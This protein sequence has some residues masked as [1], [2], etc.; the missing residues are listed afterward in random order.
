MSGMDFRGNVDSHNNEAIGGWIVDPANPTRMLDVDLYVDGERRGRVRAGFPRADVKD[1]G[2][3]AGRNGFYFAMPLTEREGKTSV[4]VRETVSQHLVGQPLVLQRTPSPKRAGLTQTEAMALM[5]KPL[6][7]VGCNAF[8]F[9]SNVVSLCGVYLP[10][11]GDPFAYDVIAEDGVSFELQRPLHDK[12]PLEY[13]WFWPNVQWGTWRIEINLAL[14]QHRGDAYRFVFR[15]KGASG[16]DQEEVLYVPKDL[17]LWQHLPSSNAMNR[18]QLYDF[19]EASPLRAAT[20]CRAI[21]RLAEQHLGKLGSLRALDWGCGWGR[22]TRTF[23]ASRT[24]GDI[25]GIDIDHE[26][27]AWARRNIPSGSFVHVPL[28]PPTELPA[29]HFDLVYAVSVMT[30]LTRDSQ[31]R[32]LKEIR[33]VLR[34][35]GLAILTFH[36]R[37]ALAFASAYLTERTVANFKNHGFDDRMECDHLDTVIGA[38]YY[39]NTFQTQDDVRANWGQHLKVVETREAAVGLQDVAILLKDR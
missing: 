28:Q 32:W 4:E 9:K 39:K 33:R 19:P 13:F 22:L 25:W 29:N 3:G 14:T 27:L 34:P 7:A 10:P 16:Q 21:A 31:T 11:G 23:V 20:H 26:N 6:L 37:T 35:G 5:K 8:S 24:F 2:L 17:T 1:Q 38:G 12:G 18:V 15:P 30:H 36:G